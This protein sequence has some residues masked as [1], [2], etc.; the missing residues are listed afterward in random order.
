M[1][2]IIAHHDAAGCSLFFRLEILDLSFDPLVDHPAVL[3]A[4]NH[5][6]VDAFPLYVHLLNLQQCYLLKKI[7]FELNAQYVGK[8]NAK[9][10]IDG[11]NRTIIKVVSR[12][13]EQQLQIINDWQTFYKMCQRREWRGVEEPKKKKITQV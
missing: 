1:H 9:S 6:T 11:N 2:L 5:V 13:S 4:P 10:C 3:H 7:N 8:Q 12:P